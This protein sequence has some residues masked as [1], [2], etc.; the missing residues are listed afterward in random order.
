MRRS[1]RRRIKENVA[2]TQTYNA[3][4]TN[5]IKINSIG[6]KLKEEK[7]ENCA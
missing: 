4:T 3:T 1:G 7:K 5:E 6:E 2:I